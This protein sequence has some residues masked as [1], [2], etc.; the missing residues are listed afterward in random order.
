MYICV[1]V[2][3]C[4]CVCMYVCV[5]VC[6]CV[7]VCDIGWKRDQQ[8]ST[9][10]MCP[11]C[12]AEATVVFSFDVVGAHLVRMECQNSL[13]IHVQL[14]GTSPAGQGA[15]EK[16]QHTQSNAH[17]AVSFRSALMRESD[18]HM[19]THTHTPSAIPHLSDGHGCI[20]SLEERLSHGG[21][22]EWQPT[23]SLCTEHLTW[24]RP[25]CKH[26]RTRAK[27]KTEGTKDGVI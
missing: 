18:T 2:C 24:E 15:T 10:T 19:H 4:V 25:T 1:C 21:F 22:V 11:N 17:Q 23:N 3:V 5:C 26:E 20:S 13:E 8:I 6:E 27:K 12:T 7:C 9:S 16:A 14:A